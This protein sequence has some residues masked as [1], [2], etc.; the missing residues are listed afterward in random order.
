MIFGPAH[1]LT[2]LFRGYDDAQH[3]LESQSTNLHTLIAD[4]GVIRDPAHPN[5]QPEESTEVS[6][7]DHSLDPEPT[8]PTE[9]PS[10]VFVH[11]DGTQRYLGLLVTDEMVSTTQDIMQKLNIIREHEKAYDEIEKEIVYSE[12]MIEKASLKLEESEPE[13]AQNLQDYIEMQ[14]SNMEDAR[15]RRNAIGQKLEI[16][17]TDLDFARK[18]SHDL[19]TQT[20]GEANL[21]DLPLPE[22]AEADTTL[23]EL[24]QGQV[25]PQAE[26]FSSDPGEACREAAM[27]DAILQLDKLAEAERVFNDRGMLYHEQLAVFR[28]AVVNGESP[29]AQSEFDRQFVAYGQQITRRL[30]DADTM[31]KE[32]RAHAIGL[33]ALESDWGEPQLLGPLGEWEGQSLPQDELIAYQAS[34]D[35]GRVEAWVES[36]PTSGYCDPLSHIDQGFL[37]SNGFCD[38][39]T[40]IDATMVDI[41]DWDARPDDV[42]ESVSV[43]DSVETNREKIDRWEAI[44]EQS[45]AKWDEQDGN[46]FGQ[47]QEEQLLPME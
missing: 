45:R 6:L 2:Q 39:E 18:E 46:A 34:R 13:E 4:R 42:W 21:I 10:R 26:S 14:E 8:G 35:W 27:E 29:D 23:P 33:G 47:E 17:N 38:S 41:D 36:L 16:F 44:R 32:A 31:Y 19:L 28:E 24:E 20:L 1:I 5:N 11:H 43:Y 12:E 7:G 25:T 15:E 30:I 3:D 40:P 37:S 9:G 22:E